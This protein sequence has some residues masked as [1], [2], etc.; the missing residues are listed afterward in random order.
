VLNALVGQCFQAIPSVAWIIKDGIY[1]WVSE[2]YREFFGDPV[3]KSVR[4]AHPTEAAER[5]LATDRKALSGVRRVEAI[6]VSEAGIWHV[7]EWASGEYLCGIAQLTAAPAISEAL[8]AS[9]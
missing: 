7:A 8:K 9:A 4:D 1:V 5:Y 3:G 6:E 2:D